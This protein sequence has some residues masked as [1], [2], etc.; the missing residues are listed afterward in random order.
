[1]ATLQKF[2][3]L[4]TQCGVAQSPTRSP[5]T[6]PVVHLRRRKSTL[7][8][9]LTR[10]TS[11]RSPR[12]QDLPY[13]QIPPAN[14]PQKKEMKKNVVQRNSLK[15]LF[16]SSP[17]LMED[18]QEEMNGQSAELGSIGSVS[19]AGSASWRAGPG[20]PRPVWSSFRY[21]SLLRRAW[22]TMLITIPE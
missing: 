14:L 1:M 22:R 17:P 10:S 11:R 13:Q 3:L 18:G 9:L 6:S 19:P 16:V 7:R 12:R 15:E 4:A 5:R 20:S 8:M 2:K 21:R